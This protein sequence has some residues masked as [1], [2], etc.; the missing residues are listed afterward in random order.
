MASVVYGI[1]LILIGLVYLWK[2]TIFRRGVWM[3]TSI[4]I[5]TLS[6]TNYTR[7]MRGVGLVCIAAGVVLILASVFR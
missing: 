3:K 6:E 5:R 1:T 7:Y 4:A 2:P